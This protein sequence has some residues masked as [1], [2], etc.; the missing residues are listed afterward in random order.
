MVNVTNYQTLPGHGIQAIIDDSMLFVGNQKLMLDHQINIQSIKMK[1]MEAE[2][3]TVMLIAYDGELRGMIAVADTVKAS[4]KA[5][6][7]LSSMN[8]RTVMLTGDNERTAK[9]IA[10][11]VGID[12]SL[13]ASYLKIK[14]II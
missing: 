7:Q 11:E 8:I 4:A 14:H 3:H 2:G 12:Q 10:K 5:I 1:Q 6:Q 13:P 9:A